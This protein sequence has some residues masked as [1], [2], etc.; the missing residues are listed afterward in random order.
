MTTGELYEITDE[1]SDQYSFAG[2]TYYVATDERL[3]EIARDYLTDDPELWKQAVE[4]GNTT[5]GLEEWAESV[6]SMD[7]AAHILNGWDGNSDE[8]EANGI[9]YTICRT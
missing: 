8:Q 4:A 7:G 2:I 5:D 9:T 1:R 6:V 3:D